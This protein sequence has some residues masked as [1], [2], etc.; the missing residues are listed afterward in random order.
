[1][2]QVAWHQT[3]LNCLLQS[4]VLEQPGA[5]C[6]P[7]AGL[8][9]GDGAFMLTRLHAAGLDSSTTFTIVRCLK[10]MAHLGQATLLVALL[11]PA[12]EVGQFVWVL[13][14]GVVL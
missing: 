3:P 12:P 7:A 11:Q 8:T 4:L 6:L 9:A 13:N 5:K 14:R 10:H 2:Q 1:M